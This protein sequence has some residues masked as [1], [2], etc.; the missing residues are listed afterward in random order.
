MGHLLVQIESLSESIKELDKEID[1]MVAKH[2]GAKQL[3]EQIAG[4]GGLTALTFVLTLEDPERFKQ[5]RDVGAYLGM[6]PKQRQSGQRSP[7]LRI[8]KTGDRY[9]RSTLVQCA[10]YILSRGPDS[11]LKRWGEAHVG[12]NANQRKRTIVAMARK[13]A[14][15]MHHLWATGEVYDPFYHTHREERKAALEAWKA[16]QESVKEPAMST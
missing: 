11:E 4:V 3:E 10:H 13:L 15:L 16:T 12:T 6:V 8:T 7:Q 14:V 9:L 2:P 5:S 1:A